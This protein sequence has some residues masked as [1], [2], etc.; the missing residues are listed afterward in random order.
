[1]VVTK[2]PTRWTAD[3]IDPALKGLANAEVEVI[4]TGGR[5]GRTDVGVALPANARVVDLM[6]FVSVLPK[7]SVFVTNGGWGGVLA[8]FAAGVPLVV[9]PGSARRQARD[10]RSG[11]ALLA[12]ASICVNAGRNPLRVADAVRE[13]LAN[14]TYRERARQIGS[15]LD[16]LGGASAAADLLERLAETRAPLLRTGNPWTSPAKSG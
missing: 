7:A 12:P 6:D 3:L 14:P 4:A 13:V 2:G 9:A 10:R 1:M 11:C 15:E 8:S 16:Q 5:R